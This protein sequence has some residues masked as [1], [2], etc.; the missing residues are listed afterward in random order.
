MRKYKILIA[1]WVIV[2][3]AMFFAFTV[4]SCR[5]DSI[6][7]DGPIQLYILQM[8]YCLFFKQIVQLLVAMMAAA[9][10]ATVI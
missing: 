9:E 2:L 3:I 10:M 8:M 5:H 4:N 7:V 1:S 6:A